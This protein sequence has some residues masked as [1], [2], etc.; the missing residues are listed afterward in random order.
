MRQTTGLQQ[1]LA[2]RAVNDVVA[3]AVTVD[4]CFHTMTTTNSK[5]VITA[6][7]T[8]AAVSPLTLLAAP[9]HLAEAM[10]A[11]EENSVWISGRTRALARSQRLAN[12][13]SF[14]VFC[15]MARLLSA[16]AAAIAPLAFGILGG[17]SSLRLRCR[18]SLYAAASRSP[19]PLAVLCCAELYATPNT[20]SSPL[21]R[22]C[23]TFI[24]SLSL[25]D[26]PPCPRIR[27]S[28]PKVSSDILSL[29]SRPGGAER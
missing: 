17:H 25:P 27:P 23:S 7:T 15:S 6:P 29:L 24:S 2:Q 28:P 9:V 18:H 16:I 20:S 26:I 10:R 19:Y 21:S 22:F 13:L 3:E 14:A 8:L 11:V 5:L 4:H 12:H 1:L